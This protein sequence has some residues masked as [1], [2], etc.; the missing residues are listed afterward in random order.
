MIKL[1][2]G[3]AIPVTPSDSLL[4]TDASGTEVSGTLYIGVTGNVNVLPWEHDAS[5]GATTTGTKGGA[6]LY[7]NV[8]VGFFPVAVKK[9]FSTGTT[10]SG[11]IAQI[12]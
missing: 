7:P 1:I 12:D 6:V 9:V 5:H 2:G 11:I 3:K 4:L 10:A 8:P